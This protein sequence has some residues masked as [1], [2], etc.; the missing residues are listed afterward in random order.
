MKPS[1]TQ[2]TAAPLCEYLGCRNLESD[3]RDARAPVSV[4]WSVLLDI[5][6]DHRAKLALTGRHGHILFSD[7]KML[8]QVR[9][10]HCLGALPILL[11]LPN[12]SHVMND[13]FGSLAT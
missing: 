2:A 8:R 7:G 6:R 12:W 1:V 5:R 4:G 9:R 11:L 13:A 3:T 10:E